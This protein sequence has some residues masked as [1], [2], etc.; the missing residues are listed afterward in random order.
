MLNGIKL[1][2]LDELNEI[3]IGY[4][5]KYRALLYFLNACNV[6]ATIL[7]LDPGYVLKTYVE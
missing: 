6:G 4:I 7:N 1:K 3:L 5:K 2:K